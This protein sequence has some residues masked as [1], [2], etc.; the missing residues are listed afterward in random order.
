MAFHLGPINTLKLRLF[1]I[2]DGKKADL[3][4]CRRTDMVSAISV[5]VSFVYK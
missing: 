2:H 1:R 3:S 4:Y 5:F